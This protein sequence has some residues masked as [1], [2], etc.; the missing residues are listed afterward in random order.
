MSKKHSLCLSGGNLTYAGAHCVRCKKEHS[1]E[2]VR[3]AVSQ[4][5]TR[6]DCTKCGKLV[7]SPGGAVGHITSCLTIG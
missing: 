4:G 3:Q 7:L 1:L 6:C 5:R 2:H